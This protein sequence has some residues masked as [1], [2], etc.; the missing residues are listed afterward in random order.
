MLHKRLFRVTFFGSALAVLGA[1]ATVPQTSHEKPPWYDEPSVETHQV[2]ISGTTGP[3][4]E[5]RSR[6]TVCETGR[7]LHGLFMVSQNPALA[8]VYVADWLKR[9]S[10]NKELK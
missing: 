5:R 4:P 6:L 9:Q 10:A 3:T 2:D 7:I 8:D 1:C